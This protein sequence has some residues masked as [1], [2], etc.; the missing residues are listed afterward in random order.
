[1]S[2]NP[3]PLNSPGIRV[4][5]AVGVAVA[6]GVGVPVG[7]L[8]VKNT[9]PFVSGRDRVF[10]HWSVARPELPVPMAGL[11]GWGNHAWPTP[12]HAAST[13]AR[14]GSVLLTSPGLAKEATAL[15]SLLRLKSPDARCVGPRFAGLK[16]SALCGPYTLPRE[17]N[18]TLPDEV[19]KKTAP[20]DP[21]TVLRAT[22]L[23]L[24]T[25][26]PSTVLM[27]AP[28][29]AVFCAIV[30]FAIVTVRAVSKTLT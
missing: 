23:A 29:R 20:P 22:V 19:G 21:N 27:A 9:A 10:P 28:S 25:M 8:A 2:T 4:G 6:V 15:S 16:F 12:P 24:M 18:L 14:S 26:V 13:R 1:M 7:T 11:P 3:S 5:V 17:V 30:L